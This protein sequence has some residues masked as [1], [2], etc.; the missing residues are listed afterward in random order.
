MPPDSA[1]RRPHPPRTSRAVRTGL[2]AAATVLS[3]GAATLPG[4]L[5]ATASASPVP[6]D[7]VSARPAAGSTTASGATRATK[8]TRG[9]V[10][11]RRARITV[12]APRSAAAGSRFTLRGTVRAG[13]G[14][15]VVTVT[16]KRGARWKKVGRD[17]TNRRGAFSVKVRAGGKER[18]RTFRVQASARGRVLARAR[19]KVRVQAPTT[20]TTTWPAA[21]APW[22]APVTVT[23]VVSAAD[24]AGRTAR[25]QLKLPTGWRQVSSTPVA[26]DGS[27]ALAAPSDWLYSTRL[28]VLVPA[29]GGSSEG[30]S[31]PW[32]LTI[33]PTW[34]PPGSPRDWTELNETPLRYDPCQVIAYRTNL[35]AAPPGAAEA[36]TEALRQVS[37]ATGLR[38]QHLGATTALFDGEGANAA[39]PK[40]ATLIVGFGTATQ[41]RA[42]FDTGPTIG[43]GGSAHG[44]RA[45]SATLGQVWRIVQGG[46]VLKADH[47]WTPGSMLEALTHEVGHAVGLG[48]ADMPDQLMYP[49]SEGANPVWG[50]GDLTGL[51][52]AGLLSGCLRPARAS[53]DGDRFPGVVALP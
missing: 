10:V 33:T 24:L 52:S 31:A 3:A 47:A 18:T 41:T 34:A 17:R 22:G 36:L 25:L 7:Q 14:V 29:G 21:T 8:A 48:H 45:R 51:R 6:S 44:V 28:R 53:G 11:A 27:F 40:D 43:W 12:K 9:V 42:P 5:P 16:E 26:A 15:R 4:L 50:A 37:L 38:F 1:P 46:A 23:G 39:Y 30:R 32:G 35:D 19:V 20:V 2:L 49:V 13:S